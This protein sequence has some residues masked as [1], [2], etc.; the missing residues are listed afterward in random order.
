[1]IEITEN[2]F[3]NAVTA[4][5]ND[6]QDNP[7]S[8]NVAVNANEENT[9]G[10]Q[11]KESN[12]EE[13]KEQACG[14]SDV[15]AAE[16]ITIDAAKEDKAT[17]PKADKPEDKKEEDKAEGKDE[18]KDEKPEGD[19]PFGEDKS[20][21]KKEIKE[22]D[23]KA[24][25]DLLK[26]VIEH[27]EAE[28]NQGEDESEDIK[29]LKEA[30]KKLGMKVETKPEADKP[31][32]EPAPVELGLPNEPVE[33][34]AELPVEPEV[35]AMDIPGASLV[36]TFEKKATIAD[37]VWMIKNASDN[38]DFL[39]FNVKAAFGADIDNDEVRSAYATSE[40]FGKDVVAALINEKVASAIGAKAAVLG[41]VAHYNPAHASAHKYA[42]FPVAN[43]GAAGAKVETETDKNLV[44]V[45]KEAKASEEAPLTTT[46]KAKDEK[47]DDDKK[48]KKCGKE[49]CVCKEE[50]DVKKKADEE[51]AI[52]KTAAAEGV[53]TEALGTDASILPDAVK[54]AEDE[55]TKQDKSAVAYQGPKLVAESDKKVIAS[56]EETIKKQASEINELKLQASIN[57]KVAKVKQAVNLMVR[58]GLLKGDEQV[59]IAALKEGLSIEAA[60]AKG[61]AASID[62]Q[63]KNL[64]G[65]NTPQ[66]DSYIKSLAALTPSTKSVQASSMQPLNV[67]ASAV[68]T[69]TERLAKILGWD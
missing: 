67:K 52:E 49:K 69:E 45:G 35:P 30:A 36:A 48:C 32:D 56:M 17:E 4:A 68:E 27:E 33:P 34:A 14:A 58:A 65:M 57:E 39:S 43:P 42:D 19:K 20:D 1:M 64:F 40:N 63:S 12:M 7:T 38:S 37:S 8:E 16:E 59:R 23:F 41:V 60:S 21:K 24:A 10:I 2:D 15:T 18:K 9:V 53:A 55:N 46:A 44:T 62:A 31:V 66:L 28:A 54:V 11:K 50:K 26:K 22:V 6:F 25:E 61:M 5:Y 51:V 29:N 13:I 47:K 3:I